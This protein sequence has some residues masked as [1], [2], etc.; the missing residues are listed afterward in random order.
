MSKFQIKNLFAFSSLR[1]KPIFIS[2]EKLI[3][4]AE[5]S[6]ENAVCPVCRK[7][8]RHKHSHYTR[9]IRDLSICG[10]QT[11][12]QLR[13]RR[14]ICRNKQCNRFI[15]SEQPEGFS[16]YGRLSNRARDMLIRI[17]IEISA[18]K[19]SAISKFLAIKI[20][21]S[22]CLRL[23]HSLKLPVH[24]QISNLGIDD[25]ALRKGCSYGTALVDMDTGRIIDLLPGRDGDSLYEWLGAQNEIKTVNRDRAGSYA[26]VV[27]KTNP[28]AEQIADRFHLIKNL[29]EHVESIIFSNSTLINKILS[30]GKSLYD[31]VKPHRNSRLFDIAKSKLAMGCSQTKVAK[32]IGLSRYTVWKYAHSDAFPSSSRRTNIF[33]RYKLIIEKEL[34]NGTSLSTIHKMIVEAGYNGA[35]SNFYTHFGDKNRRNPFEKV[36]S[37][38]TLS[39][40]IFSK[41]IRLI[42]NKI[43]KSQIA[44]LSKKLTW[45]A[46][47]N[48]LCSSFSELLKNGNKTLLDKWLTDAESLKIK[49]LSRF[50]YGIRKDYDAVLNAIIHSSSSGVIEG[51]INRL[52]CIKRQMYGRASLELLKR[53]V[54]LSTSG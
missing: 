51:N 13:T 4:A 18:N 44:F 11:Y 29:S 23:V 14:F 54:I 9:K 35:R 48:R 8:S 22:T 3:L 21:S 26:S 41:D 33:D 45:I 7:I 31:A 50:V 30:R 27:S 38:K 2:D 52:K 25:W 6:R 39:R 19:G 47:L 28:K 46:P 5:V 32:D 40:H 20:S 49:R 43:E 10:K 37:M 1:Y 42:I 53:K 17:M 16:P 24:G 12:I 15:F 34:A 36:I